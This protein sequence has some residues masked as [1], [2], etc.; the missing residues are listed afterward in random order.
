A[1]REVVPS[2][3]DELAIFCLP[4]LHDPRLHTIH[5]LRLVQ[6]GDDQLSAAPL[7]DH[8]VARLEDEV[9]V[10]PDGDK[11]I[12]LHDEMRSPFTCPRASCEGQ[13]PDRHDCP[14]PQHPPHDASSLSLSWDLSL[15]FPPSLRRF[16]RRIRLWSG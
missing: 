7:E 8:L 9:S 14:E 11:L 15:L 5:H 13:H 16:G 3:F 6:D 2:D 12:A 1:D 4:L 10:T